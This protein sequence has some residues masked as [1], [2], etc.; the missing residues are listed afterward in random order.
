MTRLHERLRT[1]LP[2]E[3]TFDF[4]ADF[5]N[6]QPGTPASRGRGGPDPPIGRSGSARPTSSACGSAAGSRR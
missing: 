5:A 1:D 4:I 2:I 3:A 6:A